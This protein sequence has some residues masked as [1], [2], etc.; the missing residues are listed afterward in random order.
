MKKNRHRWRFVEFCWSGF[1]SCENLPL[2]HR[3]LA[4]MAK[5]KKAGKPQSSAHKHPLTMD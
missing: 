3:L 5:V 2:L 4:G 1:C